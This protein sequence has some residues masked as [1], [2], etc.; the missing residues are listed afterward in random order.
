MR[1]GLED[2]LSDVERSGSFLMSNSFQ[3]NP[4]LEVLGAGPIGL[5]LS[6]EM[7]ES[8][9]KSWELKADQ[10]FLRNPAWTEQI[11]RLLKKKAAQSCSAR[12]V[13]D[14]RIDT[15]SRRSQQAGGA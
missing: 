5:P 13:P 4:G 10:F 3:I 1:K 2:A 8:G 15:G 11:K 12:P 9:Q 6:T 14:S 7:D